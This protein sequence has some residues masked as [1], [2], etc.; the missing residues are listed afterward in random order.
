MPQVKPDYINWYELFDDIEMDHRFYLD[1]LNTIAE[2]L[3]LTI[4][5]P[6]S[7][8]SFEPIDDIR[9]LEKVYH[10]IWQNYKWHIE[11]SEAM[12]KIGEATVPPI[13]VLP[14]VFFATNLDEFLV[15]ERIMHS[16]IESFIAIF[17]Y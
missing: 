8:T 12:K 14:K 13:L 11:I 5:L 2:S 10:F 4:F 16:D 6:P 3:K 15:M 7:Y 1:A 17:G 9:D